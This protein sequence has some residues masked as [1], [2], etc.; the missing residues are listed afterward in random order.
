M[1]A[2]NP[3]RFVVRL[4]IATVLIAHL[5]GC[6]KQGRYKLLTVFF[7]GVPPL[8]EEKNAAVEKK[9]PQTDKEAAPPPKIYRHPLTA[10]RQCNQCH[11]S[12]ANF[13][14]FGAKAQEPQGAGRVSYLSQPAPWK[15]PETA[16]ER[17]QGG[18][19]TGQPFTRLSR[20]AG[21]TEQSSG[22]GISHKNAIVSRNEVT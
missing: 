22:R 1:K 10:S 18:Q 2:A 4:I 8:E 7:T 5:S 21:C 16:D 11:R 14:M 17:L 6:D 12:T 20:R 3:N 9:N 19:T 13:S 15:G